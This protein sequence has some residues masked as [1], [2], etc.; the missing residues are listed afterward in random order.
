MKV[1]AAALLLMVTACGEGNV[2]LNVDVLSFLSASDS[3]KPYAVPGGLPTVDST[4]SQRLALPPGFGKST[5]DSLSASFSSQL[6][7]ATGG[8]RVAI[9]VF[10]AKTQGAL[11]TGTPYL[12]DSSG[13]VTGA[14]TVPLGD[15]QVRFGDNVFTSDTVWLG[16]RARISTDLGP[17]MTGRVRFTDMHVR[18]V[19]QDKIL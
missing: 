7:N 10:F 4:F 13:H 12:S 19:I 14:Q 18:V 16:I 8:G 15:N 11:F 3:T 5:I 17:V 1:F 9:E 6:E 2:I